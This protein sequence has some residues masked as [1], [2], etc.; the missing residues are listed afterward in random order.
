MM[1]IVKPNCSKLRKTQKQLHSQEKELQEY[2]KQPSFKQQ[3]PTRKDEVQ[4]QLE[5]IKQ[6][7]KT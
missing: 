7:Q 5:Q 2:M 1:T 3:F 6:K 4:K